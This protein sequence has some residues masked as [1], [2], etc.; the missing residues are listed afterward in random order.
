MST[1]INDLRVQEH[2]KIRTAVAE[3]DHLTLYFMANIAQEQEDYE[4]AE[5]LLKL[6]RTA[7]SK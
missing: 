7:Q 5:L 1:T 4:K 6:A 2:D 3:D